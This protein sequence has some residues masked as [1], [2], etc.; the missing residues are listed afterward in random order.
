MGIRS[1]TAVTTTTEIKIN[2]DTN[3][4]E[5]GRYQQKQ[6]SRLSLVYEVLQL[7]LEVIFF[8]W[9]ARKYREHHITRSMHELAWERI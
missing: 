7:G 1:L 8:R 2:N 5:D 9:D 6:D 3:E 4:D